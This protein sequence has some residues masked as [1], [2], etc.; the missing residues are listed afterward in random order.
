MSKREKYLQLAIIIALIIGF[1]DASYLTYKHFF[2]PL[3]TCHIGFFGDCGTVL[4]SKYSI[5]FG[6]PLAV[7][8]LVQYSA[9]AYFFWLSSVSGS[10][11]YKRLLFF[12]T[13]I[14]LLFSLYFTY[15]QI[16]VIGSFCQYCLLS[17]IT[18]TF[19]YITIRTL[20]RDDYH[21]FILAKIEFI[22]K[23][24]LKPVF[25]VLP[26]EFVHEQAMFWGE[27][28]GKIPAVRSLFSRFLDYKHSMLS[29]KIGKTAF[30]NPIGLAAGYDYMAAFPGI[31]PSV[32]FGYQ[33][34]GTI[35]NQPCDGNA[36]PRLGRLPKSQSLLVN[37]GFR[38]CGADEIIEKI[39]GKKFG[40]PF[41]VSIGRTNIEETG[42]LEKAI[43]DIVQAFKKFE[44]S[45]V[46]NDYYE[47]NISCPNLKG[48][49]SFYPPENLKKL[50]KAVEKLKL[51]KP[52]FVK[53]PIEK[54]DDEVRAM[55]KVIATFKFVTGVI[56]GNLQK[57][58]KDK[59]F[60][61]DEIRKAGKGNF[62]GKP[63]FRRSN[64]LIRLAYQEYGKRFII[65]GCGGIFTA[66]DAYRKIRYGATMLQMI[67]GMIFEGPQRIAQIN[68][69]LVE[70]LKI[71]GFKHISEAVGADA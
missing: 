48:N 1:L 5:M 66:E 31:L 53:M 67:T 24:I 21:S 3:A 4:R 54:T 65:I 49:L 68:R 9:V 50:L 43:D 8:G 18:S 57:N 23:L 56:F 45:N 2:Q 35:S 6:I 29:V 26:A 19:L 32:G 62:S 42:T 52:L 44:K 16:Y 25:F 11:F 69:G 22:Y 34:I 30:P 71:D 58:R 51:K 15:L 41:G 27:L 47:L 17:A 55:L 40:F 7:W 59:S 70:H 13:A 60:H 33:T 61:T 46:K 20:F 36:V 63:A 28:S 39:G 14:G 38:N 64:E 10:A 37:K 12:Q